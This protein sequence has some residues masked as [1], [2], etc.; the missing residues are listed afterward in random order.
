MTGEQM[1]TMATQ[2]TGDATWSEP[3]TTSGATR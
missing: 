2:T 3:G 1:M